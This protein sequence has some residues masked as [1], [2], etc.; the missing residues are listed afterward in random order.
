MPS[1]RTESD[2]AGLGF[3]LKVRFLSRLFLPRRGGRPDRDA[4]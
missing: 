3:S 1:P 2:P 4:T